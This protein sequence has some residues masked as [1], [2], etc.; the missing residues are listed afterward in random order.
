LVDTFVKAGENGLKARASDLQ[1]QTGKEIKALKATI[2]DLYVENAIQDFLGYRFF[3]SA[4]E[5]CEGSAPV[6]I[7]QEYKEVTFMPRAR[8]FFHTS[9]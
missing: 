5:G 2:G 4:T 8:N 6:A 7:V 9:V 1:K 3:T